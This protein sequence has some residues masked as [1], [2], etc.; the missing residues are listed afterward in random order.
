MNDFDVDVPSLAP[1]YDISRA[2]LEN[3]LYE[4]LSENG[5]SLVKH[6]VCARKIN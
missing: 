1:D 5:V 6:D 4:F 2:D 3:E